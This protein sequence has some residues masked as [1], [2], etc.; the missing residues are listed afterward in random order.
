M[1]VHTPQV[2]ETIGTKLRQRTVDYV[3]RYVWPRSAHRP[4]LLQWLLLHPMVFAAWF[5]AR[6]IVWRALGYV[7]RRLEIG[8]FVGEKSLPYNLANRWIINRSRT[9]RMISTVGAIQGFERSLS[10][11]LV[12]GPRNEAELLLLRA[13]GFRNVNI[14]AI[15]LFTYCPTIKLMDMHQLSYANDTFDAVYSSFVITYSDDIPRA[16]AETVRVAKDGAIIIFGFQHLSTSAVNKLGVNRLQG[17]TQELLELFG[18]SVQHIYWADN[19]N[20][21]DGSRICTLIFRLKKP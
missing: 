8:G 19:F 17:G 12:I 4:R 2:Q 20:Q 5:H 11:I 13:Y 14:E 21:P 10:R 7:P 3:G 9:E 16:V 15:D 18:A 6:R 1:N